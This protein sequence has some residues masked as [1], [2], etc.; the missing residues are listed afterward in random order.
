MEQEL[1]SLP[2]RAFIEKYPAA[3]D[4][5][6]SYGLSAADRELPFP[7]AVAAALSPS[8]QEL[9]L[10]PLALCD[11]LLALLY[12]E[13]L[14][15]IER[16]EEIE[17]SGGSDKDGLPEGVALRVRIGE[18]VSLVGP[19][20]SGKSQLLADIECA[21]RGDTP[22]G[23]HV[24]FNRTELG[25]EQRFSLGNRLVAQL[26]QNMNFVIDVSVE[27]FLRMHAHSR[28]LAGTD[29][30]IGRCFAMANELSGEP[31][32]RETRVTRLSGGQARALMIADAACISPSPVLLIDEIENA[33]IDRIRAV[34]LLTGGDKIV[35]LA[36]HDPLLAL[37][38]SRRVVLHN[39]GIRAVLKTSKAERALLRELVEENR[40]NN[41]LRR[42]IRAGERM[43]EAC[44]NSMRN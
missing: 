7:D 2:L 14:S 20:G 11:L 31:F 36:T 27:D 23:R 43:E 17:I 41:D 34:E 12:R 13:N 16:I 35:L 21:A 1:Y 39:G 25:D 9:G 22:S 37:S 40:K 6:E 30:A 33:G 19:T 4:F 38:A 32:D 15:E 10:S 28:H 44:G 8:A 18:V 42:A 3:D 5:L 29:Q 26:T 24:R